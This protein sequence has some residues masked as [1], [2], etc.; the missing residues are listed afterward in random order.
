MNYKVIKSKEVSDL[1]SKDGE[2]TKSVNLLSG[3]WEG[4]CAVASIVFDNVMP[5]AEIHEKAIDVWFILNGSG[6]FIL[7]GQ[8]NNGQKIAENEFTGDSIQG[9]EEFIVVAGDIIDIPADIAHQVNAR[10]GRLET[11]IVKAKI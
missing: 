7:G 1:S 2:G 6:K 3:S 10:G 5:K 9:G 4:P 11:I 8:L